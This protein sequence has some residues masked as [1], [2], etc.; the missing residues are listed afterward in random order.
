M[1]EVVGTGVTH[2]VCHHRMRILNSSFA[3]LFWLANNKKGKYQEFCIDY[4]DETW[5]V[6]SGWHRYYKE[7]PLF[8]IYS[9]VQIFGP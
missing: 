7:M 5:Y 9:D 6:G 4:T 1:W 2:V 8:P 3:Y